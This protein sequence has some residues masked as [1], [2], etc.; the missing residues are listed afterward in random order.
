MGKTTLCE[1]IIGF[2]NIIEVLVKGV[3]EFAIKSTS[4]IVP[5]I[6]FLYNKT[7]ISVN[8]LRRIV[9]QILYDKKVAYEKNRE[10]TS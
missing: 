3:I 7:K 2:D 4:N 5:V 1:K 10:I 6:H 9:V 8:I